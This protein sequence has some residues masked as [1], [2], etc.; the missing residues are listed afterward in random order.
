MFFDMQLS[1][2]DQKL[3]TDVNAEIVRFVNSEEKS[4]QLEPMNSYRRRLVHKIGSEFKLS[5]KS[6]GDGDNRSVCLLK[7]KETAIPENYKNS[8]IIDRGIEIF[9]AK[10]G[11]TIV[12][13]NDG[14]FGV[15]LKENESKILDIRSIEDGEFRIRENKIICKKDENW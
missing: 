6:T 7:T 5:S 2:S 11:S 1:N 15:S 8:L 9:Y 12:L 14:S 10:P 3:L 4:L 13:R